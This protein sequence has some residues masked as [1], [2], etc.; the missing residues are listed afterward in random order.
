MLFKN[1]KDFTA[2]FKIK[3]YRGRADQE[4]NTKN[5]I[6]NEKLTSNKVEFGLSE[7]RLNRLYI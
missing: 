3:V 2:N 6:C 5:I 7:M 1:F 4:T